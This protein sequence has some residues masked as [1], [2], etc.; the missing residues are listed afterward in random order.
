MQSIFLD[1]L[2]LIALS[3]PAI[4]FFDLA[5]RRPTLG[6][7]V[8][9]FVGLLA[10]TTVAFVAVLVFAAFGL[11][12]APPSRETIDSLAAGVFWTGLAWRSVGTDTPQR[13]TTP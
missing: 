1:P 5:V 2:V 7:G 4:T 9:F 13:Q 11:G 3:S 8:G 12:R 10:L 6:K